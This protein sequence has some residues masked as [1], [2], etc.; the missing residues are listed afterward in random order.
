[1]PE[2]IRDDSKREASRRNPDG[3]EVKTGNAGDINHQ[4]EGLNLTAEQQE[5]IKLI[6]IH[7][8]K[9][10]GLMISGLIE[11]LLMIIVSEK[12]VQSKFGN[13]PNPFGSKKLLNASDVSKVLNISESAAYKLMQDGEIPSV[14]MRRIVRVRLEDLEEYIRR[15]TGR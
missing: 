2:Q 8:G 7:A 15:S 5:A 1:M 10:I 9:Q 3:N 14:H 13:L 6:S 11:E 12:R 4:F